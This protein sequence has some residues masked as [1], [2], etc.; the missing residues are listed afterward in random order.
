MQAGIDMGPI[1][2]ALARRRA[3]SLGGGAGTPMTQQVSGMD[4]LQSRLQ[5]SQQTSGAVQPSGSAGTT[6]AALKASQSATGPQFDPETRDLAKSLIQ[7][8][9][10]GV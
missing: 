10:K 8:L 6:N 1:Q 5:A 9:L 3:G 4:A 7:R 2:E